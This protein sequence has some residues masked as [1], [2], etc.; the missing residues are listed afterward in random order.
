[1]SLLGWRRLLR[2]MRLLRR[3]TRVVL[4][5]RRRLRMGGRRLHLLLRGLRQLVGRLLVLWMLVWVRGMRM[6]VL[7]LMLL[8][9][10]LMGLDGRSLSRRRSGG[11]HGRLRSRRR[12]GS[13]SLA[14]PR[15]LSRSLCRC[16][17]SGRGTAGLL[18]DAHGRL[19]GRAVVLRLR[20]HAWRLGIGK[21]HALLLATARHG[22]LLLLL[23]G[24]VLSCRQLAGEGDDMMAVGGRR[25][26]CH[27]RTRCS[28]K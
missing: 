2:L 4:G 14:L 6:L 16:R 7:L 20:L 27:G 12:T 8:L 23:V 26:S 3:L 19:A 17:L 22:G 21:L 5:L 11:G 10:V 28:W 25:R 9:V 15:R 18:R 1:L 24:M 13:R